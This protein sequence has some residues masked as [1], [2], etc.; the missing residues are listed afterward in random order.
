MAKFTAGPGAADGIDF[1]QFDIVDAVND[2]AGSSF[3]GP[4]N[5][6][7]EITFFGTLDSFDTFRG[8]FVIT[9]NGTE[10]DDV[11][12]GTINQFEQFDDNKSSS[13][14]TGFSMS[15]AQFEGF[16]DKA[17]S[18]GF[19]AA[20]FSGADTI[21]GLDKTDNMQGFK[22]NDTIDGGD[23]NDTLG[24]D[25]GNDSLI[26]NLGD[27]EMDGGAGNDTYSVDSA[28][29]KAAETGKGAAGGTDTVLSSAAA[30]KLGDNIENLTLTGVGDIDG[31]GNEVA[32]VIT[33]NDGANEL[34]GA[35]GNDKLVGGIGADSLSGGTENDTLDGGAGDD[36]LNGGT[37]KDSMTGGEGNDTYFVDDAADKVSE[38]LKN[39]KNGGTDD[40]VSSSVS[41]TL[42]NNL[43]NLLLTGT[44]D[45]IGK[46]NT[47]DN[48][49]TGND[50]KNNL[51]GSTG[52]DSLD[53][54]LEADSLI[55]GAGDD[56]L[57]GGAGDDTLDGGTGNDSMDGEAGDDVY[58]VDSDKDTVSDSGVSVGDEVRNNQVAA[59]IAGIEHY[60]FT[61]KG[62]V[63]FNGRDA[64]DNRI[65][66][67]TVGDTLGGLGGDDTLNGLNGNDSLT[68]GLGL[69]DL[70][71][72]AGNDT[73]L[74][75]DDDDRLD[76]GTGV[77]KMEGGAGNDTYV[78]DNAKDA[79]KDS[80]GTDDT[81]ES[82]LALDLTKFTGIEHGTL[83]GKGSLSLTGNE[84]DNE[85]TG[86]DGN[87]KIDGGLGADAMI[88]GK[89]NDT[90]TVD[91]D[92]D[93]VTEDKDAGTDTVLSSV[94]FELDDNIENLTLQGEAVVGEGNNLANAIIGNAEDNELIGGGENDTLTGND[95]NDL[96]D[97]GDGIDKMVGGKGDD[98]YVVGN[99]KDAVSETSTG[100][101]DTVQSSITYTL[102]NY[103]ENLLLTGGIAIDGTGNKLAN[104]IAGNDAIN[105]LS[106][107]DGDDEVTGNG[108][109]DALDG[110][111]GTDTAVFAGDKAGYEITTKDGVTT[112]KDINLGDG[113]D[114]TDT[115]TTIERVQ[116]ADQLVLL[117][118][119]A[120]GTPGADAPKLTAAGDAFDGLGGN[121]TLQ[122]L[123]GTDI[124]TGG[125]DNDL[126]V[127]GAGNDSLDGGTG[128]DEFRHAIGD[129]FDIVSGADGLDHVLLTG[130]DL[131][132]LNFDRVGNDLVVSAAIDG[133]YDFA[134]T[135]SITI[136]DHY[137]GNSIAFVLIDTIY[138]ESYG[139]DPDVTKAVFT[140]DVANGLDNTDFMEIIQGSDVGEIINGNGGFYDQLYGASGDDTI[141]SG[142]SSDF[143]AGGGGDDALFGND[144]DDRLRGSAG[145]DTL[146][147]GDGTDRADYRRAAASVTVDLSAGTASDDGDGGQ[148][149]LVSI[150]DVRGSDFDDVITGNDGENFIRSL[151]GNDSLLGGDG[152]DFLVG[153]AGNDTL[154]GG[155]GDEFDEAAYDDSAGPIIANLSST[156]QLG[157]GAG[158]VKDG[159]GTVDTLIS[160]EGILATG[161]NDTII[162]G[163]GDEFFEAMGGNDSVDGG[164][165]F[166]E[167]DFF[168]ASG[169]VA[170]NLTKQGGAQSI[171]GGQGSD[172]LK[173]F[174]GINGSFFNDVLTGDGGDNFIHGR[175]GADKIAGGGGQDELVG[176]EGNDTVGGGEGDD[177]L[178]GE[179]GTDSLGGDAGDDTLEGGAGN[180]SVNG[181]TGT[182]T[183]VFGGNKADY[184]V[185]TD[186]NGVTTVK[187]LV[188]GDGDDGTDTLTSVE[189]LQFYDELVL[190]QPVTKG[191]AGDDK[192]TLTASGDVYDGLAG[193]DTIQGLGGVDILSGGD[194]ND[195]IV[196]GAGD[197]TVDGGAGT[198]EYQHSGLL[199]DGNDVVVNSDGNDFVVFTAED[200]YDINFFRDGDDLVIGGAVDGNYDFND[201]GSVRIA[202]HYAGAAIAFMQIDTEFYNLDYGTDPDIVTM[203]FTPDL[204]NGI[205]N[206]DTGEILIG[207]DAD[208][209]INGNGGYYDGFYAGDGKDTVNGG[210]GFDN[211]RG[212]EGNDSLFGGN[213]DDQL[214][215]EQ[216]D[217]TLDGGDG[218]DRARYDN[219]S[220][221]VIVDLVAGTAV[222]ADLDGDSGTDKLIGIEEVRGSDFADTLTGD[223][224][225]NRLEGR[226]DADSLVGAGGDDRLQGDGG[227]D[228]LDGGDG[229]DQ[230]RY[231]TASAGVI[232][233]LT[234][235]TA[236]GAAGDDTLISIER[237]VG[238]AHNDTLTGHVDIFASLLGGEGDDSIDGAGN[239]FAT[240]FDSPD[241]VT[242]NL[243]TGTASDG[244]GNADT[245][246]DLRG[247]SGSDH[248]DTLTGNDKDNWF[249]G[250]AG[251]DSFSGGD[252][253]D[254]VDYNFPSGGIIVDLGAGTATDNF[255][256][257][258]TLA[259]IEEVWASNAADKL[260]GSAT[261]DA[262]WGAD[263]ND[264]LTGGGGAD[265]FFFSGSVSEGKDV[266]TDFSKAGD[267]LSFFDVIDADADTDFDLDDLNA[268]ITS[269][270]DNGAGN[271]VV[272]TFDHGG[273]VTFNGA[274]TGAVDSIDDLVATPATQI[275]V[276]GG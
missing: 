130:T 197:D 215:A 188:P 180:D 230:V 113:D 119:A 77:D 108:G 115:L 145:N 259:G 265:T 107:L 51:D 142:S 40:L 133:D 275:I 112:V 263:G 269:V 177:H 267:V 212:G 176:E 157:V 186:K 255:G 46:G 37:G 24:G 138:N 110:G 198:D 56:D 94:D 166:D 76:G 91:D 23:G 31:T 83:M 148:D 137:L 68:G 153:G 247:L 222:Q 196:G 54:G 167:I 96:L 258:D 219:A 193:K 85:L 71:G 268:A 206:T 16:F 154:H 221:G 50:G 86:N 1:T 214:R 11:I 48:E 102:G 184:E 191:T 240:Y 22:G 147:G 38:T 189:R 227:N 139:T 121:D 79:I 114:G 169:G 53:G 62:P 226:G 52:N 172:V 174:E 128:T 131:Y 253:H 74:G 213:D 224:G 202:G 149:K 43:D 158:Q 254:V 25:A 47:L 93:T 29:D 15:V 111:K 223:D 243:A 225:E 36:T 236:T 134:D 35:A 72:G 92:G 34:D 99:A 69:D 252:G 80:G 233:N 209:V 65:T 129:G 195:I 13:L 165:G 42:G 171:G 101:I 231:N 272:V 3:K 211:I 179:D 175:D 190:L 141:N 6:A 249:E 106:G 234:A 159:F 185:T 181:G 82:T 14:V 67:T 39:D 242:A 204:A 116:F 150:E 241:D 239:G 146:D 161:K 60:T 271:T 164:G 28:L 152:F 109:N 104:E 183:V 41:F 19:L 32:N 90:Y 274:G 208:E 192:A 75:G 118:A 207:T 248:N 33:G 257:T 4:P 205:N 140:T 84:L 163:D 89:G 262:L 264:T 58:I 228:T 122:G 5:A 59:L 244:W 132:D 18:Q 17:D 160:I 173:N 203:A 127:G 81:V 144:G 12:S 151:G 136:K 187:D 117:T 49:I 98:T 44:K 20:V 266:V 126:I 218:A 9:A 97:G 123:G 2:D 124:L 55:G 194:D 182:D 201:S 216:G 78:V 143:I 210:D 7:T 8:K 237:V 95:G 27:D 105:Q 103:V 229:R 276:S 256:N 70:N 155:P 200:F 125:A 88:G 57:L 64:E 232:V 246:T 168:N 217:D 270:V 61:G 261:D 73:L 250:A 178:F 238:S 199:A 66:G 245:L 135:G 251:N 170:V 63:T 162:G 220:G 100:G 235:G 87:N 30:Y 156:E 21:T 10:V 273:T 120:Q 26:G 260:T 45:I